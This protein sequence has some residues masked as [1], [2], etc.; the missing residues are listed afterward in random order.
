MRVIRRGVEY[1]VSFVISQP[2]SACAVPPL[3]R[4]TDFFE[5]RT[6]EIPPEHYN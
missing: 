4:S 3:R 2:V 6:T 1:Y 5:G